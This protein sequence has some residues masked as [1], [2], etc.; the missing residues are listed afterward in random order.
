MEVDP[1]ATANRADYS[2][3]GYFFCSTGCKSMFDADPVHY[4][5]LASVARKEHDDAPAASPC[6]SHDH[7]GHDHA[8]HH[9]SA[10]QDV[11]EPVPEGMVWTCPMHLEIRWMQQFFGKQT[12]LPEIREHLR[13]RDTLAPTGNELPIIPL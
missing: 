13:V 1:A 2:G 12:G 4:A 11:K 6:H 10:A 5:A 3:S 7:H 9:H 8:D